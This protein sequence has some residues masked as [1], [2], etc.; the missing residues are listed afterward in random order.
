MTRGRAQERW[1][2][3][4]TAKASRFDRPAYVA[5]ADRKKP[6]ASSEQISHANAVAM[7]EVKGKPRADGYPVSERTEA[8]KDGSAVAWAK[9]QGFKTDWEVGLKKATGR[10]GV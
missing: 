9:R 4:D 6:V 2:A 5:P 1:L 10:T 7:N 3:Q 8:F